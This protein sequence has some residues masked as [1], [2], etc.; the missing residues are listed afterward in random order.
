MSLVPLPL[1]LAPMVC[2]LRAVAISAFVW[3]AVAPDSIPS[4]FVP[5]AAMSRPSR[6]DAKV[7][8]PAPVTRN[9]S[10]P[11]PVICKA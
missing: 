10:L 8:V 11:L 5:S 7:T 2:P 6:V 3:S 9:T 4:S 1:P